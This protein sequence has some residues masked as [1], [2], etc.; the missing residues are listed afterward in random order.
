MKGSVLKNFSPGLDNVKKRTASLQYELHN[1]YN[2]LIVNVIYA[3][4]GGAD[5]QSFTRS[6][7]AAFSFLPVICQQIFKH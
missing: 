1:W 5:F 4:A 3:P 7:L 6:P 2:V